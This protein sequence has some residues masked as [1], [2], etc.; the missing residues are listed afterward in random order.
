MRWLEKEAKVKVAFA[1]VQY[2]DTPQEI[3]LLTRGERTSVTPVLEPSD[4]SLIEWR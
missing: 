4:S 1:V 3:V 2:V